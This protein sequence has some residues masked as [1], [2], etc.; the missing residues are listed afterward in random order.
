MLEADIKIDFLAWST[1][2][3][4]NDYFMHYIYWDTLYI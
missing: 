3:E 4:I 1:F 2:E